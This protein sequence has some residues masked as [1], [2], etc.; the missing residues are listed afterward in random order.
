MEPAEFTGMHNIKP[1]LGRRRNGERELRRVPL[2]VDSR[3]GVL[4]RTGAR[5]SVVRE[6]AGRLGSAL[7]SLPCLTPYHP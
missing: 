6:T 2:S 5:T 7:A 3:L 1:V 4:E